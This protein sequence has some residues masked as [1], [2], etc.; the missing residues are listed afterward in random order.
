MRW[1]DENAVLF[2]EA[3]VIEDHVR[4]RLPAVEI[5]NAA[6]YRYKP[7]K[8]VFFGHYWMRGEPTIQSPLAACMD[9]SVAKEGKLVAYRW[10]G[11]QTLSNEGFHYVESGQS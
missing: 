2:P 5:P 9:F 11:E 6:R 10:N 1:W 3:A 4:E 7:R 8:P